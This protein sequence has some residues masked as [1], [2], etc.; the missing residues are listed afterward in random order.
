MSFLISLDE[1]DRVKR[2]NGLQTIVDLSEATAISRPTW[3]RAI[4]TRRPTPD[5]LNAL[6]ELGARPNKVLVLDSV[7]DIRAA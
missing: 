3:T 1:L 4:K 5:I 2:A 7:Q 6:A